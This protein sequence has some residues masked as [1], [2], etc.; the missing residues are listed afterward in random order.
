V[1]TLHFFLWTFIIL[2]FSL[3]FIGLIVPVM[4]AVAF[5]WV[6]IGTYHFFID[7]MALTW[8]TWNTLLIG[9]ALILLADYLVNMFAVRHYGG[10]RLSMA[11]S[12][13]GVLMGLLLFPPFGIIVGPFLLVFL[14]ESLRH[15]TPEEASKV[16][17][18]TVVA[19]F[20][21][22]A[23][24][25]LLQIVILSVFFMEIARAGA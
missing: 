17:F 22:A 1:L 18:A 3:G 12:V 11:A 15:R 14:T 8:T 23:A 9:T 19:F 24:K 6:G 2:C 4:P 25:A 7:P 5:I 13:V 10:S 20:G 16:A 21:S